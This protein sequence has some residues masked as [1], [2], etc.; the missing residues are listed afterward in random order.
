MD[1]KDIITLRLNQQAMAIINNMAGKACLGG[2][3]HVRERADRLDS[4]NVDQIIGQIGTYGCT[5]YLLGTNEPYIRMREEINKNPHI[6]DDGVDIPGTNIDVKTSFMRSNSL[7][8]L[9]YRLPVRP[10]ERH[11]D[12]RYILGLVSEYS[13]QHAILHLVGWASTDML[14][15]KLETKG[16]FSGPIYY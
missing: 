2:V 1:I 9:K 7:P 13:K 14:P 12:H 16:V 10:A 3:S 5:E 15:N 11:E 6:G 8:M 4:L